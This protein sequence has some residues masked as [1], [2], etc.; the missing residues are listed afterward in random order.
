MPFVSNLSI[1]SEN[2]QEIVSTYFVH[3][4]ILALGERRSGYF[5]N[6]FHYAIDDGDRCTNIE[7]A[8]RAA[9]HFPD[10]LDYLYSSHGFVI[11]TAN[12]VPLLYLAQSL[13]VISLLRLVEEFLDKDVRKL[14]NFGTYLSDALYFSDPRIVGRVRDTGGK[15]VLELTLSGSTDNLIRLLKSPLCS[16]ASRFS[17]QAQDW[18]FFITRLPKRLAVKAKHCVLRDSLESDKRKNHCGDHAE[19]ETS[20]TR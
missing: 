8:S 4:N 20:Q 6:L 14:F 11:S 7:I 2:R 10:L 15:E 19:N 18:W 13:Q 9:D 12:A 17:G 3:R 1:H 16:S 5:S